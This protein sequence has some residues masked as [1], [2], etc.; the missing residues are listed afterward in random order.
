MGPRLMVTFMCHVLFENF[1][2]L[3]FAGAEVIAEC[4]DVALLRCA[5]DFAKGNVIDILF[6]VEPFRHCDQH[7]S[8][9]LIEHA[10]NDSNRID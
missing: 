9:V 4:G 3:S 8:C 5:I 7:H 2:Q 6:S 10:L 1:F